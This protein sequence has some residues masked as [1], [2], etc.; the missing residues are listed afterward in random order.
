VTQLLPCFGSVYT[1]MVGE[2]VENMRRDVA[3][4]RQDLAGLIG[5]LTLNPDRS[6][7]FLVAEGRIGLGGV[8]AVF[9]IFGNVVAGHD[10]EL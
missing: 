4:A 9:P 8:M 7:R 1:K 6:G 2:L 10:S 5:R 3:R